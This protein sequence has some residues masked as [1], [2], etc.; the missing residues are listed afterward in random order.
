MGKIRIIGGQ[1]RSRML[2]VIDSD[3]LCPTSNRI[4]ETLFN[5]LGQD[6]TGKTCLDM[7]S[8]SGALGFEAISRNATKV[9]ML[10]LDTTVYNQLKKNQTMLK[11]DNV[12]II[13]ANAIKYLS[14]TQDKYD[15]IFL[16]PPYDSDLLAKSLVMIHNN[17]S[18]NGLIFVEYDKEINLTGYE[19]VKSDQYSMVKFALIKPVLGK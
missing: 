9:T 2:D 15:V 14:N 4:R 17:L 16:D 18:E 12:E 1:Y 7:F 3:G 11:A 19:I 13:N 6:L 5:W 10:E 8:G